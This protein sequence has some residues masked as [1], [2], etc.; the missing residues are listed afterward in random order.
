MKVFEGR[1]LGGV[2]LALAMSATGAVPVVK[3]VPWV[4]SNPLI[5]HDTWSGKAVTLKGTSDQYGASIQWTWDFGDGSP[6]ATGTV[7]SA[8]LYALESSHTYVGSDGTTFT[9]RLTVANGA[10][11]ESASQTYYVKISTKSLPVEVNVAIDEGLWALH[12]GM[13]RST[14]GGVNYGNWTSWS[15]YYSLTPA[16]I[17]AFE[18]NGHLESGVAGNPYTETVKRAMNELFTR[19][20][21]FNPTVQTLGDPDANDN[22]IAIK[23]NQGDHY[24]QT[25]MFMDALIASGTPEA[26]APTGPANVVGRTYKEIVQDMVDF[27][28]WGQYDSG[29][30]VRGGWRYSDN[31]AP[32]NSVG[33]WAA[34]GMIPAERHWGCVIPAW[35]KTANRNWLVYSQKTVSPYTFGYTDSNPIWTGTFAV[36]PSGM[37]QLAWQGLGRGHLG[38]DRAETYLRDNFGVTGGSYDTNIKKFYYGLFAFVKAMLLHDSNEDGVAEPIVML[39]SSTPG[40]TPVDWYSAET[41]SV[42]PYQP[43]G[44]N[45]LEGVAR[46]LVNA[47]LAN[48]TWGSPP[49]AVVDGN[50]LDYYTAWAIIMLQRTLFESGAPV[51]VAKATPNPAV[52]GQVVQLD[53]SASYHQDSGKA[54]DSWEWDLDNDGTYDV[55]GP[56]ASVSFP[57]LGS[58]P[59]K[60]RVTDD[61]SPEASAT[62]F[63]TVVVSIPPL[64]PSADAG[65]PY[66][67]CPQSVP[68]FLDGTGSTNPDDGQSEPHVPPYPGDAIVSYA[69]DL[70]GNGVFDNASGAQPDVTAYFSGLPAGNHVIG[71]KVTDRTATSFPSSNLPDQSD[72]DSAVVTVHA[73]T[74][75]EC[76]CVDNLAA[77]A[78]IFGVPALPTVQLTWTPKAGAHHYN[79]YRGTV[80][81]GPYLKI[82]ST[83]SSYAVFTDNGAGIGL[84]VG[85]TYYYVIRQADALD[86]ELCQSNEAS[87]RPRNR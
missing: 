85:Q 41:N 57:A 61:A 65:G 8:N 87:A 72:T 76:V 6:V 5:P 2:V 74:D 16:N 62:T 71:L 73:R 75:P 18:V 3:T 84:T 25:G 45:H 83:T 52:A 47:Q 67:F 59:V 27:Y 32:D 7:T 11:G 66:H 70:D 46:T 68:W 34:I 54:I 33:Q 56:F 22:N 40:V 58:Y 69:W 28:S 21:T 13:T 19:L 49:A 14:S 79:V 38:W 81:G 51:A 15:S 29:S 1:W 60:L 63:V 43:L 64:A 31:Q 20:T 23:V 9:A 42:P 78:K 4:A 17:M 37:V 82:G 50:E 86:R 77:R 44:V 39:Q 30:P 80:A 12:K 35:V 10:T 36:T 53:G 26:V 48:K 55:T 24:Y